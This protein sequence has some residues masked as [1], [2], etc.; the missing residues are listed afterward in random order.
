MNRNRRCSRQPCCALL[1]AITCLVAGH[2]A[3]PAQLSAQ[4][5]APALKNLATHS[6]PAS[7]LVF[8]G[9]TVVD[10]TDGRLLPEQT[11]VVVGN[12]VQAVGPTRQVQVPQGAQVVEARGKYLI[13][14]LWDMHTH[15]DNRANTL[16][17]RFIAHGVTGIRE[18]GQRFEGGT[19]SFRVWQRAVATGTRVGPRSVGPNVEITERNRFK[20]TTPDDVRRIVD[21]LQAAGITFLKVHGTGAGNNPTLYFAILREARRVGLPVVGHTPDEVGEVEVADSGQRSIEHVNEHQTCWAVL[22]GGGPK[23]RVRREPVNVDS[24]LTADSVRIREQC[25]PTAAAFIRNGTWLTPTLVTLRAYNVHG[26]PSLVR[27]MH[28]FGVRKFLAGTDAPLGGRIPPGFS[29]LQELVSFAESGLT[30]LE[31]LQTATLYPAQFFEATD[32]LGTVAAGKLADLVLLDANP[33]T[34]IR[35]L[36]KLRAV[37]ANGRYFDRAA[38]DALDPDGVKAAKDF[39]EQQPSS[40]KSAATAP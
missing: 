1:L 14:G 28:R 6:V 18:M 13:P 7:T 15:V 3:A 2:P 19:D 5:S 32:S 22:P 39:A 29:L 38:L 9:G 26:A 24:I 4:Q 16:Y 37:V 30:P 17:P 34:D 10:V 25:G 8:T 20:I 23:G 40:G 36:L 27:V 21:S 11:V 35:N 31:A 33:L 12:R